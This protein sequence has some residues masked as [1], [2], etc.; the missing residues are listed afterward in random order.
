MSFAQLQLNPQLLTAVSRM[1]FTEPTPIQRETIPHLLAGRDVM[2]LAQT[3][4]GKTAAFVLP[5]LH[6]LAADTGRGIRAL[7]LS[8][9]RELSEQTH[10]AIGDLAGRTGLSSTTIYGGVNINTQIKT[11][12]RGV[13][14][15][16]ACPGRLLDHVRQRTIDLS[17]VRYLVLDE[18][19]QMFDMGFLPDIRKILSQLTQ[20]RQRML[21]SATMPPDILSLT[22][23]LLKNP[24]KIQV[25]RIA[26]AATVSH[27]FFRVGPHSK[28]AMLNH[29]LSRTE[30]ES[31]LVFTRTKHRS[32]NLARSLAA[33]GFSATALHGNLSQNRR[34][35]AMDGFRSGAFRVLVATDVAARGI[36]VQKIAHVIN[37][38]MPGTTDAYTHRTGRTGRALRSGDAYTFVDSD[39][40]GTMQA[41]R[42]LLGSR[43]VNGEM[44]NVAALAPEARPRPATMPDPASRNSRPRRGAGTA[45]AKGGRTGAR[46]PRSRPK[47]SSSSDH[48]VGRRLA[49]V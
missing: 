8:P 40:A 44:Q 1:G 28:N 23:Q 2:G 30:G 18:A 25:D 27:T 13:D 26:P 9:T 12:R 35:Q 41:I 24:E 19:D 3:G 4:T 47:H 33:W 32:K 38:D 29:L 31:V 15:V 21:F 10:E 36:D 22:R 48:F 6:H 11:L 20:L 7:I 46:H 45:Q 37:Y 49:A 5:L 17:T 43:C 14:I 16:V 34:Q 39:D 42:R